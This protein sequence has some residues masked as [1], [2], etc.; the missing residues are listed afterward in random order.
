MITADFIEYIRSV[1]RYSER[2]VQIY[3]LVLE[4]YSQDRQVKDDDELI[5]SLNPSELRSYEVNLLDDRKL[6]PKTV[7]LHLSVLSRF[8]D[9]LIKVGRLSSN[10]VSLVSRPKIMKRV[11]EFYRLE[12]MDD[13]FVRTQANASPEALEAFL[14]DP[15]GED[16]KG[17]YCKRLARLIINILY[18][19][20]LRR[21]EVIGLT[22]GDVDFGRKV[23]KVHGKGDKMREI[24]L[25]DS[26][27]EEILLYLKA[28]DAL[29]GGCRSLID[30]LLVT[31]GLDSLYPV[32]LDRTVKEELGDVDGINGRK[33][34][35][36]LR[37]SIATQLLND[38]ADLN[39]IKEMLGH[40]SLATTQIYTHSSIAQLKDIYKQAHPRAKNGGKNGD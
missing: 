33:S 2:T 19:L 3:G 37:H 17:L 32:Y 27:S 30:P 18:S 36:V 24:P 13:Y 5:A 10:P 31:Y 9:Y 20:G 40:S 14:S 8:C 25:V 22:L 7:N 4:D 21:S 6:S 1:R 29:C 35:H 34:P 38:G 12:S 39:S 11:P 26:L 23:V 28:V 15:T 16:G